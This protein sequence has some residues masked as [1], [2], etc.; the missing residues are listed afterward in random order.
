MIST[1]K[2]SFLIFLQA[3][4]KHTKTG[5]SHIAAACWFFNAYFFRVTDFTGLPALVEV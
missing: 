5:D 4:I 2:T 3:E 1:K